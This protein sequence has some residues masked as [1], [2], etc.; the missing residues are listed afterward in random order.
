MQ[1][2]KKK[3][4]ILGSTG[5]IGRQTLDVVRTFPERFQVLA[6][7]AGENLGLLSAQIC[8]FK[9]RF[10]SYADT[11]RKLTGIPSGVSFELLKLD[12]IATLAESDIVVI[13]TSGRSGLSPTLAALKAGKTIALANKE[14]LVMAGELVMR[15]LDKGKGKILPLDSE[16]SAIW[17]CL[18]GEDRPAKLILTASGG[19]FLH[20][21]PDR[22]KRVTPAEALNHPSWNMGE[23][24]TIDSATLMNKGLEVIEAHYL[25]EM[26]YADILVLVHP[27]AI[28]HSMVVFPDGA[29]KGQLSYPDMRLP[30]QYAL[31]Y[32]ERTANP[33]LPELDW[34]KIKHLNLE[35]PDTAAFPCLNL[36]IEAGKKGGT[37]PAVL[38][39]ADEVAVAL[40]LDRQ[41][42]F[43]DIPYL[44][45]ETLSRH[46]STS[47]PVL[48]EIIAADSW[49]REQAGKLAAG[50]KI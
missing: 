14:A 10:V 40:F 46:Q 38:C 32:P 7:G 26:P 35:T 34:N 25:F 6:L 36:A 9:P 19:P 23:K 20:Y 21:P 48:E 31:T 8:E 27:E 29:V 30:I 1:N 49:A 2:Q 16:H 33:E 24:I 42:K 5:S 44:I 4:A 18:R 50:V 13:A 39:G 22:L 17:Q 28:I 47:S 37:Y 43:T 15:E 41:I 45:D 11:N 3:I 12:E